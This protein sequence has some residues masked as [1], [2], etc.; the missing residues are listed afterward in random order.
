MKKIICLFLL[1]SLLACSHQSSSTVSTTNTFSET[2]KEQYSLVK[3]EI[4]LEEIKQENLEQ[5]LK[6]GSGILFFGFPECPWC[7]EYLPL[8]NQFLEKNQT[9]AYYYNI[10]QD[11]HENASFYDNIARIIQEKNPDIIHY[12]KEGRAVIYMPLTLFIEKGEIRYF[13]SETNNI[14]SKEYNPSIYWDNEKKEALF[15]R[16]QKSYASLA[17]LLEEMEKEGCE[18]SCEFGK[19]H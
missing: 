15:Q 18:N 7:Q 16:L 1:L 9:S 5:F 8:L 13:E 19:D 17:S 14:S 4:Y 10:Y 11:K 12:N 2:L 3:N 6:H